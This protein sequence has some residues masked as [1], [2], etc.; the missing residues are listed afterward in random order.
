MIAAGTR[1]VVV[2]TGETQVVVHVGFGTHSMSRMLTRHDSIL[3][4]SGGSI[5]SGMLHLDHLC[6][7]E[8][9]LGHAVDQHKQ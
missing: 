3:S 8:Q 2:E 5:K 6:S 4:M 9:D 1:D 7:I